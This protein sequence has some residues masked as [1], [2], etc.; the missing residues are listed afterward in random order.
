MASGFP[1]NVNRISIRTAEALYQ[2][3]RFPDHPEYQRE[4][5]DQK[6]PM[7]AKMVSRKYK[8]KTRYDWDRQRVK[9]MRWCLKIKFVQNAV[10]LGA[11]FEESGEFPIVEFSKKDC[12][13]G[14][15]P[16]GE[17]QLIGRNV[18]G[19]LL[20]ELRQ[21]WV[22]KGITENSVVYPLDMEKFYLLAKPIEPVMGVS[23]EKG[24]TDESE[25][26]RNLSLF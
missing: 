11:L 13:W 12:F 24:A 9:V 4:I 14:A 23:R 19:R 20:M 2:A 5:I 3:C 25:V 16:D 8:E 7:T 6:S 18:L 22:D 21:Q 1:L 17:R 26:G 15:K 10:A